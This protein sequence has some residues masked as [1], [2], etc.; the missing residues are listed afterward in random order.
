M[1]FSSYKSK[2]NSIDKSF[3]VNDDWKNKARDKVLA[4]VRSSSVW[5]QADVS[6]ASSN[7]GSVFNMVLARHVLKP[8]L[9]IFVIFSLISYTSV[10]TVQAARA[11]LPGDT[12]YSV[13]LGIEKAQVGL[14]FS[15]TK[16]TELEMSFA[17]TRLEEVNEII[18]KN[19]QPEE[20]QGIIE[21][22]E[23][24]QDIEQAIQQFNSD[25][26]S[27][28]KRL[29]KLEH[30]EDSGEDVLE[31][32][33]LVNEKTEE[34]EEDLLVIKEKIAENSS[35][36]DVGEIQDTPI[37]SEQEALDLEEEFQSI[38]PEEEGSTKEDSEDSIDDAEGGLADVDLGTE[39]GGQVNNDNEIDQ[40]D[41]D[42]DSTLEETD[43]ILG[44]IESALEAVGDTNT[45]S[46]E[47]FVEKAS[48]S[49]D[50]AVKK[51]AVEKIEKKIEKIEKD[52]IEA[53]EKIEQVKADADEEGVE[54]VEVEV[55]GDDQDTTQEAQDQDA[56]LETIGDA[57]EK[58]EEKPKQAQDAIDE[59][60]QILSEES[61]DHLDEAMEKI[62][63]ANDFVKEADD[64]I[65]D[66]EIEIIKSQIE[67]TEEDI[68]DQ[69]TEVDGSSTSGIDNS[70][71]IIDENDQS[72]QDNE[73]LSDQ[74]VGNAEEQEI[75]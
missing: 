35:D 24:A 33:K 10:A 51:E 17:T 65:K 49:D 40:E 67:S 3:S 57:I 31:I 66:V 1:R 9:A 2:L 52:I 43:T 46:L 8:V 58:A 15:E 50:D 30:Q 54:S 5:K 7:F 61:I 22:Q 70:E 48:V 18:N 20:D 16:K 26:D 45:K 23:L 12:L 63:Q 68:E 37:V 59:V 25:L 69:D 53:E 27:V 44:S 39:A 21:N 55:S 13:K 14:T 29:E 71:D 19:D 38:E 4:E 28:Q 41:V 42:D 72:T 75:S 6:K 62:I 64:D 36:A 32:S 56:E 74:G 47:V 11:S 73:S 34:L 60:K